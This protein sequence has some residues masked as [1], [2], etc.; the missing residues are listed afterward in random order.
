MVL[1]HETNIRGGEKTGHVV[2]PLK[3]AVE[4]VGA[5]G[6]IPAPSPPLYFLADSWIVHLKTT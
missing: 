3:L 2:C 1:H 4:G 6:E 5:S